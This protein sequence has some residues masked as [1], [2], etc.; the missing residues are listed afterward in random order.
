MRAKRAKEKKKGNML[1]KGIIVV[2]FLACVGVI[3][4]LAPNYIQDTLKGKINLIINNNNVTASLKY[5][6]EVDENNVVYISSKDI[7]NFFD[8]DIYYDN[9]YNQIITT[10]DTKTC[11]IELDKKEMYVNSSKVNIYSTATEKDETFYMPFSE[12]KKVY[13]VDVK[14]SEESKIVTIDS[15]SKQ[16]KMGNSSKDASVKYK[17]TTFSK[18]LDKVKKGES[19]VVIGEEK[20]WYKVRTSKRKYR[21]FKRCSKYI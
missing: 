20:G 9:K 6:V 14:Y 2:L 3:I 8:S 13:N 17:P 11:A 10:S 19:V 5:D 21:I 15:L 1:V 12:M 16:Q 4:N 18:T 7:A